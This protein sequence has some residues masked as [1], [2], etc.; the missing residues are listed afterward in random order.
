MD[1]DLDEL[2]RRAAGG[3]EAALNEVLRRIEP[4]VLRKCARFL[5]HRQDAEEACQD[6]LLQVARNI[7]KFEGRSKFTTWLH[8]VVA[9][10]AR[11][12][13]RSLKRRAAEQASAELPSMADPRTTSVIAGSRIDLLDALEKLEQTKPDLVAPIVLRDVSQMG[14]NEISE[15]LGV[16]LGTIKSR[17]HDARKF[18]QQHLVER[19]A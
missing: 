13:Y 7:H 8:V 15:H 9:N 1:T 16:P 3:D 19:L 11:Q 6:A 4:D 17:I 5:P 12:T 2:A 18:V 10:C 14:Y